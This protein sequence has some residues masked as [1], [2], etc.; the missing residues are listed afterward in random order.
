MTVFSLNVAG[1]RPC[2]SWLPCAALLLVGKSTG[3][4]EVDDVSGAG[5]LPL[6]TALQSQ[7][8]SSYAQPA[9]ARSCGATATIRWELTSRVDNLLVP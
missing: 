6:Y 9:S 3:K 5:G 2:T 4:A 8:P 7:E 1:G